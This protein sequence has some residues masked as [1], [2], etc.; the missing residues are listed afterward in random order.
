MPGDHELL[1][2]TNPL[3]ANRPLTPLAAPWTHTE[4]SFASQRLDGVEVSLGLFAHCTFANVSFKGCTI[5]DSRFINCTFVSC[6][7]RKAA[8]QNSQFDGCKFIDCDFPKVKV[9][10]TTF[11]FPKFRGCFIAFDEMHPN[12][13]RE[14]GLREMVAV[15]LG[16]EAYALGDTRDARYYHLEALRAH[17]HHL[18]QAFLARSSYYK[19]R[20]DTPA[21]IRAGAAWIAS[22]ANRLI[23]GNG[24]RGATLLRNFLI[25]ALLVFPLLFAAVGGVEPASGKLTSMDYVLLSIDSATSYSGLSGVELVSTGARIVAATELMVGLIAFGLFITILFRRITR[26]R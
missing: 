17:E 3:M 2:L 19:E 16:R 24:E 8:I 23:W 1:A 22:Q 10:S 12:L 20:Y 18:G 26:W 25:L 7:F 14:P 13:P 11:M 15:E 5:N 9:Q 6:Y 21:R 4:A